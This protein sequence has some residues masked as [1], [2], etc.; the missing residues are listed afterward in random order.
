MG[1]LNGQARLP[2]T[3]LNSTLILQATHHF[4]P[5][6]NR[7]FWCNSDILPAPVLTF[8][9][10]CHDVGSYIQPDARSVPLQFSD[11]P[12]YAF[13]EI[14]AMT[15]ADVRNAAQAAAV[16]KHKS[17]EGVEMYSTT[18]LDGVPTIQRNGHNVLG[19]WDENWD[20]ANEICDLL[21]SLEDDPHI[22][23]TEPDRKWLKAMDR[24]FRKVQ[25]A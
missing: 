8:R 13:G 4:S 21:N 14:S 17:D 5:V 25:Y 23:L 22:F 16:L 9:G 15:G 6:L 7:W 24:A 18:S 19:V 12:R 11:L 1:D 10:H 20:F 2:N 3:E